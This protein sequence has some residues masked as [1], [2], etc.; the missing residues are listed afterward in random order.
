MAWCRALFLTFCFVVT[1][2]HAFASA[3]CCWD[4]VL[5]SHQRVITRHFPLLFQFTQKSLTSPEPRCYLFVHEC[6]V[7]ACLLVVLRVKPLFAFFNVPLCLCGL[8]LVCLSEDE[9]ECLPIVQMQFVLCF[10]EVV[11]MFQSSVA[12]LYCLYFNVHAFLCAPS[13]SALSRSIF[14]VAH[15]QHKLIESAE[16]VLCFA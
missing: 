2:C 6:L 12:M 10:L 15:L 16:A 1:V 7:F 9:L 3:M 5:V 4:I 8:C 14:S 11:L 13:H